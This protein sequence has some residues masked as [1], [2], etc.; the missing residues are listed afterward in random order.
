LS[1]NGIPAFG[2]VEYAVY[3]A[4]N[5]NGGDGSGCDGDQSISS[6]D[7]YEV[8]FARDLRHDAIFTE[9]RPATAGPP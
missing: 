8:G 4:T 2:N 9:T 1:H 6:G 7:G 3:H 5:R